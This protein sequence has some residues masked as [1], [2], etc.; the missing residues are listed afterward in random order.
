MTKLDTISQA[1]RLYKAMVKEGWASSLELIDEYYADYLSV[2][3][4]L[5]Y[6]VHI[7]N[8]KGDVVESHQMI[9]SLEAADVW[10]AGGIEE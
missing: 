4:E 5:T 10:L 2:I 9:M 7:H 1:D 6:L 8:E 3:P